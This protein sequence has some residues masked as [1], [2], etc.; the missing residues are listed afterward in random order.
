MS[1]F[2]PHTDIEWGSGGVGRVVY[3]KGDR[4]L[5]VTFHRFS[6]RNGT[7]AIANGGPAFIAKDYVRIFRPAEYKLH[8]LDREATDEDKMRFRRQWDLYQSEREQVP[9]G[10]PITFIYPRDPDIVDRLRA[11][12]IHTVE[13]LAGVSEGAGPSLGM[14]WRDMVERARQF[15]ETAPERDRAAAAEERLEQQAAQIAMLQEEIAQLREARSRRKDA[16]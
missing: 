6:E 10:Y 9:D 16:A 3:D 5:H 2:T 1:D 14:G 7:A 4:E 12:R 11:A 15:L 13:Q 8:V